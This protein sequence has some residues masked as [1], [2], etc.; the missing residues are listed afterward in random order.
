MR[1]M[2]HLCL[3]FLCLGVLG[4]GGSSSSS[5]VQVSV[6]VSG[7]AGNALVLQDNGVDDLAISGNGAFTFSTPL[8][9]GAP[10]A[11]TVKTA[12]SGPSQICTV[13]NGNGTIASGAVTTVVVTCSV[14][15]YVVAGTITGLAGMV[16]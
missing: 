8:A 6:T 13:S 16:V 11:V 3:A 4:C 1:T 5:S 7:L 15:H 10:F 2:G 12:P 9:S 14:D